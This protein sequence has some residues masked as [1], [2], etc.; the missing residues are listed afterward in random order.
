MGNKKVVVGMSG[1]VD[2]SMAALLLKEGGYGVVGATLKVYPTEC[3]PSREDI[4]CDSRGIDSA[5]E[6]ARTLGIEHRVT[7][8]RAPFR[9]HVVGY[10]CSA[11]SSGLTPNPC[12][13]CNAEIKFPTLIRLA[14]EYGAKFIATGHYARLK[15]RDGRVVLMRGL[16]KSKDQAYFLSRLPQNV[17]RRTIFPLGKYRKGEIKQLAS[18]RGLNVHERRES[19]E[20]CF[21]PGDDYRAFLKEV[22]GDRISPGSIVNMGGEAVGGHDGVEFYTVGQR[23]GLYLSSKKRQY[24]LAID[25]ERR[26][27]TVGDVDDLVRHDLL[28]RDI[29]WI[30]VEKP[31]NPFRALVKIR[32]S[33]AGVLSTVSPKA[34][35]S[36]LVRFNEPQRGVTPGQAAVFYDGDAVVGGGWIS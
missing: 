31:T 6:V 36:A 4:C 13:V 15:A 33:H 14:D 18:E 19:Q 27:I 29:N 23:R 10:F 9:K 34:N 1:G 24:V 3:R 25:P 21:V 32:Y 11:Y 5:R 16:D 17:L 7:D 20:I 28:V 26:T 12:V 35:G 30:G 22:L 8:V 2:S